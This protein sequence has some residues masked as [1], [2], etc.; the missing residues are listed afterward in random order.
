MLSA[1]SADAVSTTASASCRQSG[2][3]STNTFSSVSASIASVPW[4]SSASERDSASP[5]PVPVDSSL[6]VWRKNGAKMASRISGGT[7]SPSLVTVTRNA[8]PAT[9][10]P[11]RIIVS[12]YFRALFIRLLRILVKASRSTCA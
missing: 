6:R 10:S 8:S 1:S 4:C 11:T 3:V 7:T 5:I 9:D 12:E 2:T